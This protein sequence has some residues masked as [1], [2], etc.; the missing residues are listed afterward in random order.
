MGAWDIVERVVRW[1]LVALAL[2]ALILPA[3][4]LNVPFVP[5]QSWSVLRVAERYRDHAAAINH[6]LQQAQEARA[7]D[8]AVYRLA[9]SLPVAAIVAGICALALAALALLRRQRLLAVASWIGLV[10]TL[11]TVA[12]AW[13]LTTAARADLG[14]ALARVQQGLGAAGWNPLQASLL[15]RAGLLPGPGLYLLALAFFATLLLPPAPSVVKS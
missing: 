15:T 2:V 7:P 14:T 10:T 1:L 11:Y 9:V 3:L 8:R 5:P 13:W 6:L 4:V 12:L